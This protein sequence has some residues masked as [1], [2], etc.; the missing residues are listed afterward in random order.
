MKRNGLP[1]DRPPDSGASASAGQAPAAGLSRILSGS[2]KETDLAIEWWPT[3]RPVP[4]NRNP[5][6][7]KPGGIAKIAASIREFGWRQPIVVDVKDVICLGHGRLMAAQ[8]MELAQV[9]VHVARDLTP[10]QIKALRI[11][12]NR[13]AEESEWDDTFLELELGDLKELELDLSLTG[14]EDAEVAELHQRL[15]DVQRGMETLYGEKDTVAAEALRVQ[16]GVELGQVWEIPSAVNPKTIH[17]LVVGDALTDYPKLLEGAARIDGI[18]SDPDYGMETRLVAQCLNNLGAKTAIMLM[19]D[20]QAFEF[21]AFWK[22]R[23][24]LIFKHK[25]RLGQNTKLPM[26]SHTLCPIFTRTSEGATG[27]AKPRPNFT[28]LFEVAEGGGYEQ[29]EFGQAKKAQVFEYMLAGFSWKTVADPFAGMGGTLI[30]CENGG[31]RWLGME[32]DPQHA[33]CLLDRAKGAGLSPSLVSPK[34]ATATENA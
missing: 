34:P 10:E 32:L 21:A 6:K 15:H 18:C 29:S 4:Y 30:A 14:F 23:M 12:D 24:M 3:S 7:H 28:T 26:H 25:G 22:F 16:W 13:S 1:A 20:S 9:P 27:F 19:G 2:K 33:A 8:S 5:R 17:R 11:M 31:R